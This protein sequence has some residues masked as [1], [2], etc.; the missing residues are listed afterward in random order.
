MTTPTNRNRSPSLQTALQV[1]ALLAAVPLAYSLTLL[2]SW[3][4]PNLK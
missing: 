3:V 1:V 4:L 2:A